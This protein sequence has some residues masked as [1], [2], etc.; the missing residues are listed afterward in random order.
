MFIEHGEFD[1][2]FEQI[3]IG[4]K[5]SDVFNNSE[6][7]RETKLIIHVWNE[8]KVADMKVLIMTVGMVHGDQ[9][10]N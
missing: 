5:Y 2:K 3:I 7:S 1:R 4:W 9:F 6:L 10:E 8:F